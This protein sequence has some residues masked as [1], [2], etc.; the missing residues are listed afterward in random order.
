[1]AALQ[2]FQSWFPEVVVVVV[3]DVMVPCDQDPEDDLCHEV[4]NVPCLA[5]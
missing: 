4:L 3:T 5:P 2:K 1:M